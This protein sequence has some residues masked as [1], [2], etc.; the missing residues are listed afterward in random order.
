MPAAKPAHKQPGEGSS[1]PPRLSRSPKVAYRKQTEHIPDQLGARIRKVRLDLGLSLAQVAGGNFSR[2]F[3]NQVELGRSRPSMRTLQLIAD[4]LHRPI[5]YFLQSPLN[6]TTVLELTLAEA[7]M[8]LRQADAAR[9]RILMTELLERPHLA[10]D[11]RLRAQTLLAEALLNLQEP[12]AAIPVLDEAIRSAKSMPSGLLLPDLYDWMGRA[13][14]LL[15]RP[16]EAGRWFDRALT[17]YESAGGVDP[18][19]K[20]RILGHRANLHYVAGQ[21]GEA[22]VGYEA[23]IAEAG[24]IL[25]MK[26]LG[27]IYEGLALSLQQTG[28]LGRALTYAQ[29]SLRLFETL[30]EVRMSAQLRNNMAEI[31]LQQKQAREAEAQFIQGIAELRAVG[32][33]D[34]LPHLLSGAAEAALELGDYDSA[35]ARIASAISAVVESRDPL[36]SLNVAR[37]A[38]RIAHHFG[39]SA[40]ARAHFEA[41]LQI[42]DRIDSPLDR[43]RVL[44]DYAQALEAEGDAAQAILRYRQAYESRRAGRGA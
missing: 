6:S 34:Y 22:I 14:Y 21:A 36:A 19:L 41:A 11:I 28:Q 43:G 7:G 8:R 20:A 16:N 15:R 40:R 32:D 3:L 38:G 39:D 31:L 17:A 37:I 42:A 2:A 9:A 29:R 25:D 26:S 24:H 10:A 5:E 44:Y 35:E 1:A 13:H 12:G 4:R 33:H 27:G 30:N 18:V 23:A